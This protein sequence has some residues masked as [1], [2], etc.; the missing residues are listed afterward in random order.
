ME[1]SSEA[2]RHGWLSALRQAI[3]LAPPPPDDPLGAVAASL[4]PTD[5]FSTLRFD[6]AQL[7]PPPA[8]SARATSAHSHA[9]RVGIK[10]A[11][12][13]QWALAAPPSSATVAAGTI[14]SAALDV[15][16]DA[17]LH[18]LRLVERGGGGGGEGEG[19]G[20]GGGGGK[21]EEHVV[22]YGLFTE[23]MA[24]LHSL[25]DHESGGGFGGFGGGGGSDDGGGGGRLELELV[26]RKPGAQRGYVKLRRMAGGAAGGAG[27]GGGGAAEKKGGGLFGGS[28]GGGG[29]GGHAKDGKWARAFAVMHGGFLRWFH[30]EAAAAKHSELGG[31]ALAAAKEAAAA[32]EAKLRAAALESPR[33]AVKGAAAAAAAGGGGATPATDSAASAMAALVKGEVVLGAVGAKVA[34]VPPEGK[35]LTC[36]G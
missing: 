26:L 16:A 36:A 24:T 1:A 9:S 13:R 21:S 5:E 20:G 6:L 34:L 23:A 8:A 19:K 18:S 29:G 3:Y 27:G 30:D 12:R 17:A 10:F 22:A 28:G 33:A 2:E 35:M 4:A 11:R 32:R 15:T 7:G 14:A 31:R 25:A